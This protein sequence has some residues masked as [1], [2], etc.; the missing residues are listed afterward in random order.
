MP[1]FEYTAN[2]LEELSATRFDE[3][4]IREREDLQRLLRDQIEVIEPDLLIISEE[5]SEWDESRRRIDLLAIDVSANLVVIE[6]KRTE[7]GGHMELQAIRYAAM[8]ST[9]TFDRAVSVYAAYIARRGLDL[10][11]EAALI[12]FLGWNEPKEDDFATDVR[13]ILVS[14]DFSRE[15]TTSVI[16]LAERDIDIRCVRVK[17]Y[18]RGDQI[19]LDVQQIIPLPE[20]EEYQIQVREKASQERAA[21]H[22]EGQR[23]Q[24][25]LKFW[26]QFLPKANAITPLHQNASPTKENWISAP[27]DGLDFNYV[28][29]RDRGRIELYIWR[30]DEDENKAIFDALESRKAE[31]EQAFGGTLS[32]QRLGQQRACRI[33]AFANDGSPSDESTWDKLHTQMIY[34][35]F[36]LEKAVSPHIE[37]YQQGG[38]PDMNTESAG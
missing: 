19:L 12:D 33:A 7:D 2:K 35:M 10:D 20:A 4:G 21:R 1:I 14:A 29:A 25:Y 26:S 13:I 6:L 18:R 34:L 23:E 36:R 15:L 32:W 16:W 11:A 31:I 27:N 28:L 8:V 24:L 5:F 30:S 22:Q 37:K 3:L 38:K 17:P 9:M